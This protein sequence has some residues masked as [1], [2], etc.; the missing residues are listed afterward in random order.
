MGMKKKYWIMIFIL[1]VLTGLA[2]GYF[3]WHNSLNEDFIIS[4]NIEVVSSNIGFRIPGRIEKRFVDEGDIV[5]KG[6]L[7][8]ILQKKDQEIAEKKSYDQ[9][10]LAKYKLQELETGTRPQE[11]EEGKAKLL[12]AK[13][14]LQKIQASLDLA[15]FDEEK[16]RNLF[17]KNGISKREYEVYYTKLLEAQN[18]LGQ[19]SGEVSY[20][21]EH[22][23]LL[24]EGPRIEK[25]EQ[26]KASLEIYQSAL[27]Q[28]KQQLKYTHIYAPYDGVVLN[29]FAEPGEY[30]LP[31]NPVVA[32]GDLIHVWVRAYVSETDLGKIELNQKMDVKTDAFPGRIF[33]GRVSFISDQAEFTPK[34]VQT[35]EERVKLMY[36]V[37]IDIF[38]EKREL[39][40]GMPADAYGK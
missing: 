28:A 9:V 37:K 35:F 40:A 12:S 2:G 39:K 30:L 27:D 26:A 33:E 16:F 13:A 38:N 25:I 31:G 23:D 3:I 19:A 15:K 14:F 20:N 5:Q 36:R 24:I 32:I 34:M 4:G 6:Q 7:L 18:S 29:K 21:K 1:A 22:L 10:L 8:A 17:K 11:I